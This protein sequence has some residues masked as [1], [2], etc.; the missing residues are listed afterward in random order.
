MSFL[1]R[2]E[3]PNCSISVNFSCENSCP[4][5][6]CH[7]ELY[8]NCYIFV[9]DVEDNVTLEKSVALN[10]SQSIQLCDKE[11]G[12]KYFYLIQ[13]YN[14]DTLE[15]ECDGHFS[16][17]KGKL[18]LSMTCTLIH[19]SIF[20]LCILWKNAEHFSVNLCKHFK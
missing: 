20:F 19:Y 2:I 9:S 8:E 10:C 13:C 1:E 5:V 12:K 3:D 7:N 16:T 15:Q 14:N 18:K 6:N 17:V 4:T 11:C